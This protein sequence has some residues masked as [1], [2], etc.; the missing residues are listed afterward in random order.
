MD[1]RCASSVADHHEQ[2]DAM[3]DDGSQLVGLVANTPVVG[4]GNPA[5]LADLTQ[6]VRIRAVL[7]EMI[8]VAL[9]AQAG[10]AQDIGEFLA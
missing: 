7:R 2:G 3:L 10:R 1:C 4:D 9:Y 6:P 5:S 8:G